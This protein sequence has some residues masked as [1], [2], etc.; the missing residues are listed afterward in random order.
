MWR[1]ADPAHPQPLGPPLPGQPV[2]GSRG[3]VQP[4]PGHVACAARTT[5]CGSGTVSDPAGAVAIGTPLVGHTNQV[6]TVAFTPDG[7]TLLTG[8]RDQ[9]VRL[10]T[11][12]VERAIER[13]CATTGVGA[14]TSDGWARYVSADLPF[15]PPCP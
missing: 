13:I 1:V 9:T 6:H 4:R 10:W 3:G 15:D 5:R 14:L 12:D 7:R 8:S 11:L 2:Q